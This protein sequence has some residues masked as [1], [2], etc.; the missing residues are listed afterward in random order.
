MGL[1]PVINNIPINIVKEV[2]S[3]GLVVDNTFRYT[4][5]L[6]TSL[7]RGYNALRMLYPHRLCLGRPIKKALCSSLVLSRLQYGCQLFSVCLDS[8]CLRKAQRLQNSCLRF[9][10]GIKKFSHISHTLKPTNWLNMANK[11]KMQRLCF[12]HRVVSK[13]VPVYLYNK[14]KYRTDIHNVNIRHKE[15]IT[16]P[17]HR[18]TLFKRSFTYSICSEYNQLPNEVKA[19]GERAFKRWVFKHLM[20]IQEGIT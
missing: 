7:Q 4:K 14:I 16:V 2:N 15:M 5:H 17:K 6:S 20:A 9:I 10:Y 11:F 8:N 3:L 13:G 1:H 19:L 12:Y 18:T